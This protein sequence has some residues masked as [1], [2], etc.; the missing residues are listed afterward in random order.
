MAG[1]CYTPDVLEALLKFCQK[2]QI[3]VIS[4]EVYGLSVWDNR[5]APEAPPFTSLLSINL[6]NLI[7]PRL[8]HVLWGMSKV[9]GMF[10]AW[11]WN[12]QVANCERLRTLELMVF[13]L[14]SS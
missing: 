5:A 4:D 2:H 12:I 11:Q 9:C 10:L 8:V 3:H 13:A 6:A 7:D 14:V 1:R